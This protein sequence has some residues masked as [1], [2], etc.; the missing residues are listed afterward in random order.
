MRLPSGVGKLEE[1]CRILTLNLKHKKSCVC[2]KLAPLHDS[3]IIAA[4]DCSSAVPT[5]AGTTLNIPVIAAG[6]QLFSQGGERDAAPYPGSERR[7]SA[8]QVA[9]VN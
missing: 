8:P 6:A 7:S 3:Y 9:G 4:T 2:D 1:D 5:S